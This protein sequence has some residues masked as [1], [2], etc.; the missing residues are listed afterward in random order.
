[1]KNLAANEYVEFLKK[2]PNYPDRKKLE[3]YIAANKK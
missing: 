3:D 2:K 1:M